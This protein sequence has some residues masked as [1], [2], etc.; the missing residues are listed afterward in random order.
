[1]DAFTIAIMQRL[2]WLGSLVRLDLIFGWILNEKVKGWEL[3]EHEKMQSGYQV[4]H[5]HQKKE[6]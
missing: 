1:M 2:M 5:G 4:S 6:D 3:P